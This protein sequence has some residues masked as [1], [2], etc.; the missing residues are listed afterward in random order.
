M[1]P[2]HTP[3]THTHTR[4]T[5]NPTEP[6]IWAPC[7]PFKLSIKLTTT[8][9]LWIS[10][11]SG[12][13]DVVRLYCFYIIVLIIAKIY[14]SISRPDSC[15]LLWLNR[16]RFEHTTVPINRSY[17]WS[18]SIISHVPLVSLS[19]LISP[20]GTLLLCVACTMWSKIVPSVRSPSSDHRHESDVMNDHSSSPLHISVMSLYEQFH[21]SA[22]KLL[23]ILY[24]S[25]SLISSLKK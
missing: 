23:E 11:M 7:D 17:F 2:P 12:Y 15:G 13:R 5:R 1:S 9:M 22:L 4:H 20:R 10:C 14:L 8:H 16:T 19:R 25:K 6:N 21:F 18:C 3:P 24:N